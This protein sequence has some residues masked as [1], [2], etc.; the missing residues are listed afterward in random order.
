MKRRNRPLHR[1]AFLKHAGSALAGLV[2]APTFVPAS[3]LGRDRQRPAPSNR[4]TLGCIGV[5]GQGTSNLNN[6]LRLPEIQVVAVCDV[7][8]ERRDAAQR[9]VVQNYRRGL[10]GGEAAACDAYNDFREVIARDDIDALSI[11]VP[12]HWHAIPVIEAAKAGKDIYAEK[13]LALTIAQGRAMS[14][15][16]RR[17]GV[18]FQ[19]GS[20]QR[21]DRNF[22]FACELVRNERIGR[23]ERVEIGL[24][25]GSRRA[26]QPV[27]EIPDGFDYEMWLGPAPRAPYTQ[28]RC[29]YEFRWILDYSGGQVTDWGAHHCDIA[30]W[31][32]GTEASGPIEV[33]GEGDFPA[34][35][36]YNAAVDYDFECLYP[37]GATA[38]VTNGLTNGLTFYG[39]E[40]EVFVTRGRISADPESLLTTQIG[41]GE[42]HLYESANHHRNFVECIRT[43]AETIAPIETAHRS[44]TVAHLGNI[45]MRL[46]R[47]VRWNPEIERFVN[48][49]EADRMLTRAMRSPWRLS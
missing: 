38:R 21:S 18:V 9:R 44:I 31:A 15:A 34:D 23:L 13:P 36:L 11:A 35:G 17:A 37:S 6:F 47:R 24:P 39:T 3:A 26:T 49:P 4:I 22:R 5:G 32:M 40:G 7:D 45:A 8:G 33:E 43:R 46:G 2:A 16:V 27:M 30:Q 48:D 14:D 25:T 20:Q 28:Y 29:H 42:I 12:D 1:R 10:R 41:A 19:T